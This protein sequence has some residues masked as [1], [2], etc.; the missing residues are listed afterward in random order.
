MENKA[1]NLVGSNKLHT[2]VL[3][4]ILAVLMVFSFST[5]LATET[6][7]D[8]EATDTFVVAADDVVATVN[9]EDITG[10]LVL[11]QYQ[12]LVNYYGEPDSDY[13]ELYYAV[14]MDNAVTLNL[15]KQEAA[16]RGLDQFTQ[17]EIDEVYAESDA[18]WDAALESYISYYYTF[19]DET[20]DEEKAEAY[21]AAEEY[22]GNL[23]YSKDSL[24]DGYMENALYD[25]VTGELCKDVTVSDEDVT[26]AYAETVESDRALY[27]FDIDAYETQVLMYQYGYADAM[28]TYHPEGYRYIKHIL[29]APDSDLLTA[30]TDLEDQYDSQTEDT[31]EE[32]RVTEEEVANAKAAVI[33]D[34]QTQIDE[35]NAKLAEGESFEDLIAEYGTDTGMTSGDYPDGY[36]VAEASYGYVPEF[37]DAAFSV[38][39]IGDIS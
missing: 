30:Y 39:S 24:R 22:Y 36:E 32:D 12:N 17:E 25:R 4:A 2:K 14:A 8:A 38:D 35:I 9:G 37:V 20:T 15:I 28:P 19:T 5:A 10:D 31:A 1:K 27:E 33:A 11:E 21:A 29:L 16:A 26:A 23:G 18:D 7:Q 6:E 3:C 13:V 34:V